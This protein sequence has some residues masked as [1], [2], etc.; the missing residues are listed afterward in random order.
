MSSSHCEARDLRRAGELDQ[1]FGFRDELQVFSGAWVA[2][3]YRW[4]HGKKI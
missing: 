1:I 3:I 2:K 4:H